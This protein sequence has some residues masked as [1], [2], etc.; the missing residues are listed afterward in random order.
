MPETINIGPITL[1]FLKSRHET[2]GSLDMFE[3]SCQPKARMPVP[4]Y[5]RDWDESV[6]GLEGI[7]TF[8]L[9]GKAVD[10]G[11]GDSVFI[12]RGMVHGFDILGTSVAKCLCIL[13]PGVLGPEYFRDIA[14]LVA[15]GPPDPAKMRE[16]MSRYGL[17]PVPE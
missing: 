9:D 1:R 14:A 5:H 6:Y 7:T 4:H 16:V 11:P 10:V 8:T 12:P 13:T 3:M 2:G 17:I 15:G